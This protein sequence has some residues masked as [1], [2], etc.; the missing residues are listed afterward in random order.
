MRFLLKYLKLYEKAIF[1]FKV[2]EVNTSSAS[3]NSSNNENNTSERRQRNSEN[4][5]KSPGFTSA[6]GELATSFSSVPVSI[7]T[8]RKPGPLDQTLLTSWKYVINIHEEYYF[9]KVKNIFFFIDLD[10]EDHGQCLQ[11]IRIHH[12]FVLIYLIFH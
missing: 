9:K 3:N 2:G 12:L 10:E 6:T 5:M 1:N 7:R 4:R 8:K 11:I